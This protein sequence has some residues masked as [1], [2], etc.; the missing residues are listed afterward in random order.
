[1]LA[2]LFSY[3]T[4][5]LAEPSCLSFWDREGEHRFFSFFGYSCSFVSDLS[6]RRFLADGYGSD[7]Y[8]NEIRGIAHPA[9]S[10]MQAMLFLRMILKVRPAC[11][12]AR[13]VSGSWLVAAT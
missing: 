9:A 1:M 6:G 7:S 12:Q 3:L 13:Y 5:Y 10:R 8:W 11:A 4:F 2:S